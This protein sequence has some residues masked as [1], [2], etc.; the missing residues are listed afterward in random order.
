[1]FFK[2]GA[3]SVSTREGYVNEKQQHINNLDIG[4]MLKR[5]ATQLLEEG[6][7]KKKALSLSQP[8]NV[9]ELD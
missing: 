5:A 7:M 6:P 4:K 9:I 8:S 3:F 1:M 2:T